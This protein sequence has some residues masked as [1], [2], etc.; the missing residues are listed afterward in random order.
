ML[1]TGC[2]AIQGTTTAPLAAA[3]SKAKASTEQA[4]ADNAKVKALTREMGKG[5]V[6]IDGRIHR[7][8]D[9]NRYLDSKAVRALEILDR[10]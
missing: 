3:L 7:A 2:H 4:I 9:I 1:L 5:V 8:S 6:E 10:Y